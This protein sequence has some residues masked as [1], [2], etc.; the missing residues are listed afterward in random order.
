MRCMGVDVRQLSVGL[1]TL[2]NFCKGTLNNPLTT[3][4]TCYLTF[5]DAV[6]SIKSLNKVRI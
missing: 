2:N 5:S 3:L 1:L 6:E 4:E